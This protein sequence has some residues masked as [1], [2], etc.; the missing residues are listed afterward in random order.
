M[1]FF[2]Q[3]EIP[4]AGENKQKKTP[5]NARADLERCLLF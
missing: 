1:G 4:W 2:L 5:V 3:A